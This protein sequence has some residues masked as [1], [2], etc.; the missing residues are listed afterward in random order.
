MS[1]RGLAVAVLLVGACTPMEPNLVTTFSAMSDGKFS[2]QAIGPRDVVR[3]LA[4]CKAV[5][6]VEKRGGTS[7][8]LSDPVYSDPP[9]QPGVAD[10]V[11]DTWVVLK[12]TAYLTVPNPNGIPTLSVATLAP[13]CRAMWPWYR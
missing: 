13:S 1:V 2:L 7:L 12:A 5:W 9:R 6:F 3:E 8:S 10:P 11:P 4:V